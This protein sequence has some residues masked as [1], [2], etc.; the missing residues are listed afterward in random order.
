MQRLAHV[1]AKTLVFVLSAMLL[2]ACAGAHLYNEGN[3][4]QAQ[5]ASSAFEASAKQEADAFVAEEKRR[6][7]LAQAEVDGVTRYIDVMRQSYLTQVVGS[8]ESLTKV[9][10]NG[11]WAPRLRSLDVVADEE[12]SLSKLKSAFADARAYSAPTNIAQARAR[13]ERVLRSFKRNGLPLRRKPGSNQ[14]APIECT[15]ATALPEL[16]ELDTSDLSEARVAILKERYEALEEECKAYRK[17]LET[18]PPWLRKTA[19]EIAEIKALRDRALEAK[20][21]AAD[22][23]VAAARALKEAEA[24][25][26]VPFGTK[27]KEI[28]GQARDAFETASA[29]EA[30][31]SD[32]ASL[33]KRLECVE[34]VLGAI[35]SQTPDEKSCVS[36]KVAAALAAFPNLLDTT[37]SIGGALTTP[38]TA[39]LLIVKQTLEGQLAAADARVNFQNAMLDLQEQVLRAREREIQSYV[40]LIGA[41]KDPGYVTLLSGPC[42]KGNDI[43]SQKL[44]TVIALQIGTQMR[45]MRDTL[46]LQHKQIELIYAYALSISRGHAQSWRGL[47]GP[48]IAQQK[49]F[50]EAGIKPEQIAALLAEISKTVALFEIAHQVGK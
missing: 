15:E 9:W 4:I 11:V 46:L 16:S 5:T 26:E 27:L 10:I 13:Y 8:T 7:D 29:L 45:A 48:L 30:A 50:H 37:D 22:Q 41:L 33:K 19:D 39:G 1:C 32:Q 12:L 47:I 43:A 34:D 23:V 21:A 28:A 6:S 38:N 40:A 31:V 2:T 44:R 36:P 35:N 42:P 3:A 49:A 25:P 18:R 14:N 24:D 17:A 20:N